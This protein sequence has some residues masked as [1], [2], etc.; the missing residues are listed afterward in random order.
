MAA[1]GNA[2][3]WFAVGRA[4]PTGQVL[5][6]NE[7]LIADTA[8]GY[9]GNPVLAF[10]GTNFRAFWQTTNGAGGLDAAVISPDRVMTHSFW[11]ATG[12]AI[13]A[14]YQGAAC[15][16]VGECA[17]VWATTGGVYGVRFDANANP[18]DATPITLV[19]PPN[20]GAQPQAPS[21]QIAAIASGYLLVEEGASQSAVRAFDS[22]LAPRGAPV[23]ISLP[24]APLVAGSSAGAALVWQAP[25]TK[26]VQALIF[27]GTGA[28]LQTTPLSL[29]TVAGSVSS[30]TAVGSD[31][32]LYVT[33]VSR[34]TEAEV[35]RF[36]SSGV[37]DFAQVEVP[38]LTVGALGA[39]CVASDG[40]NVFVVAT[41]P[42]LSRATYSALLG[43]DAPPV[44]ATPFRNVT[45]SES[46]PDITWDGARFI[47][48]WET[49]AATDYTINL[50]TIDLAGNAAPLAT[51]SSA[52]S[53]LALASN[54]SGYA[55]A[56]PSLNYIEVDTATDGGAPTPTGGANLGNSQNQG[57]VS[58]TT[59]GSP[60]FV[61]YTEWAGET[62]VE[63]LA[64]DAPDGGFP[65][66]FQI[67]AAEDL[68][69]VGPQSAVA[70]SGSAYAVIWRTPLLTFT[71]T[72]TWD[73][74]AAFVSPAGSPVAGPL[75]LTADAGS[76]TDVTVACAPGSCVFAWTTPTGGIATRPFDA[77][78]AP[79]GPPATLSGPAELASSLLRLQ[80]VQR[81]GHRL[82]RP[83]RRAPH[84]AVQPANGG[85][86]EALPSVRWAR[87]ANHA[88]WARDGG[89]APVEPHNTG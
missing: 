51:Y 2:Y 66:P 88:G 54:G 46:T 10:D 41:A 34:S 43:N 32:A 79:S 78:G 77:S 84:A 31:F 35:L 18:L 81:L 74:A 56:L 4:D 86:G 82:D 14:S 80:P 15:T 19:G 73:T 75:S 20:G 87:R 42:Q 40:T 50:G 23:T 68:E 37:G 69:N 45:Q 6:P 76:G 44:T 33:G 49:P 83:R 5:A 7:T 85:L 64:S 70:W 28:P 58:I 67:G 3:T 30:V 9:L 63:G 89:A 59:N 12:P 65:T 48:G 55:V 53:V 57:D 72:T 1:W 29:Q 39:G 16:P 38:S 47:A 17:V 52:S 26:Q 61:V 8:A 24:A 13:P 27:D 21:V 11:G 22:T 36:N 25:S 62:F 60:Y 71:S